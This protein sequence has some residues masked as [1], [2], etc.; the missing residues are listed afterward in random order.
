VGV[1][2]NQLKRKN[3]VEL[4]PATVFGHGGFVML[5][6]DAWVRVRMGVFG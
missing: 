4:V 3:T 1:R 5:Q 2:I 6:R